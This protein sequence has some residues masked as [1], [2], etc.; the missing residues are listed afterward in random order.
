MTNKVRCVLDARATIG[1]S[2]V[3][4]AEEQVLYWVDSLAPALYRLDPYSGTQQSWWMPDLIGSLGLR[5]GR[6]AVVALRNGLN[7]LDFDTGAL[8][9][10][11]PDPEDDRPSTRLN[12]GKVGPDGRFWVGGMDHEHPRGPISGL[13]R[14]DADH[15]LHQMLNG[16][17]VSNGLAW[18]PD[19]KTMYHADTPTQTIHSYDYDP[20]TGAIANPRILASGPETGFPDGGATDMEG[21]YWSAGVRA[22]VLNRWSPDGR[23]DRQIELPIPRPTCPCF[24]GPDMKTIFVTS[25][26]THM[27]EQE[28]AENPQSGGIFA[29][30]VDV[31]GTPVA[32]Y[33]G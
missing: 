7:L 17:T 32:R 31:P 25:L 21:F 27:S 2:P 23:L 15:S 14:L 1:E 30:D 9:L 11:A 4:S 5:E 10:I 20:E 19:G 16:L 12:D 22:G 26:R 3:W 28:L 29:V 33:R 18:S 8:T 13:Y 6:G 24:G